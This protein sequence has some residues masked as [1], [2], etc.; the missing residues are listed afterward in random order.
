M[1]I[2]WKII[3]VTKSCL[4]HHQSD[5]RTHRMITT[6]Q[7][8]GYLMHNTHPELQERKTQRTRGKS[9]HTRHT[10]RN[11]D[12]KLD[13]IHRDLAH[14]SWSQRRNESQQRPR[15]LTGWKRPYTN[16]LTYELTT[17]AAHVVFRILNPN[18]IQW[19]YEDQKI[20]I[21]TP[22]RYETKPLWRDSRGQVTPTLA[23]AQAYAKFLYIPGLQVIQN[24][25]VHFH[26][27]P[28]RKYRDLLVKDKVTV[29]NGIK[30][31]LTSLATT[32]QAVF[33]RGV[34]LGDL[35]TT[36]TLH[37]NSYWTNP[38]TKLSN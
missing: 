7:R 10:L 17:T 19:L 13:K 21:K 3:N 4:P 1:I 34:Y 29:Y 27:T 37:S 20:I 38:C 23:R 31:K 5:G 24:N 8:M 32:Q 33:P 12:R 36:T 11:L 30:I 28:A 26:F 15:P 9:R 16:A 22:R 18:C 35:H 2:F 25:G 14:V 6:T